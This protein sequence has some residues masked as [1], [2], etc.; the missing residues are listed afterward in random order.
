MAAPPRQR[1]ARESPQLATTTWRGPR[2]ATTAV[3]PTWSHLG[4]C[5]SHRQ[6]GA[7]ATLPRDEA[8][9]SASIRAKLLSMTP[10]HRASS[11]NPADPA[12][13][14]ASSTT[15]SCIR[16]PHDVATCMH[17]QTIPISTTLRV[18]TAAHARAAQSKART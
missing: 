13:A 6:V 4:S 5:I 1:T 18:K 15:I 7:G 11:S 17:M 9:A 8:T 16:C 14:P 10:L 2:T 12:A 3:E